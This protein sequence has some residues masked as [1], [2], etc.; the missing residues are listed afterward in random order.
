M[1]LVGFKKEWKPI[2]WC[3]DNKLNVMA[4]V[5]SIKVQ[6]GLGSD[7]GR[8]VQVRERAGIM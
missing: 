4:S 6:L 7:G 8:M 2:N 5:R 3:I 1:E